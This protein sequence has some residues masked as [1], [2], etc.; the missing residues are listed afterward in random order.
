MAEALKV[1]GQ[2][3]PGAT[4]DTTLYTVPAGTSTVVSCITVANRS[5]TPATYRIAVRPGGAAIAN[6]HYLAYDVALAANATEAWRTPLTLAAGDVIT[7]RASTANVSFGAFG[8]EE[9]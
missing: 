9:T 2:Q 1:L 7:V 6:Q 8:V 3:A 4:T 5:A